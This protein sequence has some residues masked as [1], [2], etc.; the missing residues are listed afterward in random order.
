MTSRLKRP[1]AELLSDIDPKAIISIY[2]VYKQLDFK[3]NTPTTYFFFK[4]SRTSAPAFFFKTVALRVGIFLKSCNMTGNAHII[5]SSFLGD[6]TR[7]NF[8]MTPS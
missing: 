1:L 5:S 6:G 4:T 2:E 7:R 3:R 8:K